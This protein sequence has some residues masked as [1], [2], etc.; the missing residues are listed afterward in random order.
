MN[1]RIGQLCCCVRALE[2]G[3]GSDASSGKTGLRVGGGAEVG[4]SG[5][6]E[7]DIS[8]LTRVDISISHD[9][10]TSSKQSLVPRTLG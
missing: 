3:R 8:A 10:L 4:V 9:D 2:A 7:C 6:K 1:G 5:R